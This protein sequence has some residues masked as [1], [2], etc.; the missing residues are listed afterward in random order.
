MNDD[1]QVEALK[2]WW[3]E[4]GKSIIGGVVLGLV[5]VGGWQGWQRYSASQAERA[6]VYFE[7][8]SQAALS[9]DLAA[10][11]QQGERLLDE[12]GRTA[13]GVLTALELAELAYNANDPGEARARLETAMANADDQ[14]LAQLA[15]LRL[16]RL[17]LDQ[18]DT[19]SAAGLVDVKVLDAY[20]GE[21]AALRGDIAQARGDVEAAR[22]AY[23]E[24]LA[25][26]AS[27]AELLRMKLAELGD[28]PAAG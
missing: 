25:Q 28:A 21:Y 14:A 17:A 5:L 2:K 9:G 7:Q 6:S 12:F 22:E 20:A 18:G 3:K 13:Y 10:A 4:N 1:D 27:A 23:R 19:E 8:F 11:R 26:G 15:R 24:A 16:A